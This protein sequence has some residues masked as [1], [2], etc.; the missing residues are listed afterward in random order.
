M[1][2]NSPVSAPVGVDAI[3]ASERL[4][5]AVDAVIRE[6][7]PSV[8]SPWQAEGTVSIRISVLRE[9]IHARRGVGR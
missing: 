6:I 2:T 9:L 3:M 7:P 8:E 1:K 4:L 5:A